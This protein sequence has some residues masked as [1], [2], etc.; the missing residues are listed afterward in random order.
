MDKEELRKGG[1]REGSSLSNGLATVY[2]TIIGGLA[3]P[4]QTLQHMLTFET[5]FLGL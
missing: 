4:G 1:G 5:D 3:F 2:M